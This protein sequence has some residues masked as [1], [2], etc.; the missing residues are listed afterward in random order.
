MSKKRFSHDI[1]EAV[2]AEFE[3]LCEML[4]GNKYE[5]VEAMIRAFK[6]LPGRLQR[7]LLS[8][9]EA[10]RRPVLA[11]LA[12]LEAPAISKRVG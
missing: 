1:D 4:P 9:C 3:A 6:A 11:V 8:R 5:M 7:D 10:D 12:A 2:L